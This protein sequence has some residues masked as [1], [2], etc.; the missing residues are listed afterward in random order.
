MDHS[1]LFTDRAALRH[2]YILYTMSHC[3]TRQSMGLEHTTPYIF[4]KPNVALTNAKH[5][6]DALEKT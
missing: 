2:I 1:E 6:A 5:V 3:D 4:S